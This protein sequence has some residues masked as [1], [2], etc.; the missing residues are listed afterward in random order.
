[1]YPRNC[2]LCSFKFHT[3]AAFWHHYIQEPSKD[4]RCMSVDEMQAYGYCWRD[5]GYQTWGDTYREF[6]DSDRE[7]WSAL[8]KP[9]MIFGEL[10]PEEDIPPY[11]IMGRWR[12]L[13]HEMLYGKMTGL[14]AA[15]RGESARGTI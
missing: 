15:W 12:R 13:L 14:A 6:W 3:E 1:M 2:T 4:T 8:F 7:F 10:F 5:L 11:L 9:A